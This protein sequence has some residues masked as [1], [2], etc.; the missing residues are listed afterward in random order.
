MYAIQIGARLEF[1]V[2]ELKGTVKREVV[3]MKRQKSGEKTHHEM[4]K[5]FVEQP[6]GYM[7]YFPRGHAIRVP[8]KEL[9]AFY[10]LDRKPRIINLEGLSDPNSPLGR[11]ML[12]QDNDARAGA[13][14]DLER[15]V[16]QLATAKTGPRLTPEQVTGEG[17]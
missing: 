4:K 14:I 11:M 12:A 7:V 9:L 8:T 17:A 5:E 2:R 15:Q 6:A 3:R 13:M 16:I 10:G 1:V